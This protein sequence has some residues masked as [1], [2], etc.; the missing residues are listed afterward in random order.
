MEMSE[1]VHDAQGALE[2]KA[3][4]NVRGLVDKL[5]AERTPYARTLLLALIL[6]VLI[7]TVA[8]LPTLLRQWI[9]PPPD[10]EVEARNLERARAATAA[11]QKSSASYLSNPRR[12]HV[13]AGMEPRFRKYVEACV[14]RIYQAGAYEATTTGVEGKAVVSVAIR[15]DGVIED[16]RVNQWSGHSAIEPM[17]RRVV[18]KADPCG[19]FPE[20]IRKDTDILHFDAALYFGPAG[21]AQ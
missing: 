11:F 18:R 17:A 1:E 20:E 9:T 3:L 4:Q 16:V 21:R 10:K 7:A 15:F 13:D 6:M 8:V 5:E 12:T 2:K 14:A 19:S